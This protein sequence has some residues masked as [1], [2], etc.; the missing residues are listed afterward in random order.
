M[1]YS[2]LIRD[3]PYNSYIYLRACSICLSL[4]DIFYLTFCHT[5]HVATNGQIWLV[6]FPMGRQVNLAVIV[7]KILRKTFRVKYDQFILCCVLTDCFLV[8]PLT[9]YYAMIILLFI[10]T[11]HLLI[12]YSNISHFTFYTIFLFYLILLD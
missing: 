6:F 8:P 2:L 4:L 11:L 9:H 1:I 3:E 7:V 12:K 5:L 10:S